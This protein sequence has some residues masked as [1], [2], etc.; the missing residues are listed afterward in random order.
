MEDKNLKKRTARR[1]RNKQMRLSRQKQSIRDRR[2]K[3]SYH[4]I[5]SFAKG[6]VMD[7]LGLVEYREQLRSSIKERIRTIRKLREENH[8]YSNLSTDMFDKCLEDFNAFDTKVED[9]A[10]ATAEVESATKLSEKID[11]VTKR[12][13][14]LAEIQLTVADVT[15][16]IT[17]ANTDFIN[18]IKA[19]DNPAAIT[20]EIP[21]ENDT[22]EFDELLDES[23]GSGDYEADVPADAIPEVTVEQP[24]V[25]TIETPVEVKPA[26]EPEVVDAVPIENAEIIN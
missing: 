24:K 14:D 3:K 8:R 22:V 26:P 25:E 18:K 2:A 7:V 13:K 12:V 16:N 1:L 9:L 20:T 21:T 23:R 19:I 17:N 4:D 15:T 10:K 6:F 5:G 11:L